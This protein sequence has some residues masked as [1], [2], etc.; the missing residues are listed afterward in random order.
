MMRLQIL[1]FS[2]LM[3]ILPYQVNCNYCLCSDI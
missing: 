2:V 1:V 3:I